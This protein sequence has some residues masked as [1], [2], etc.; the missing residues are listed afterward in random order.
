MPRTLLALGLLLTALGAAAGTPMVFQ[1]LGLEE[2]LS[3][4]TVNASLQDSRGF[5]WFATENGLNRFDGYTVTRFLRD[6][7]D[8]S[9]LESDFIWGQTHHLLQPFSQSRL[10]NDP[11]VG[12]AKS[13]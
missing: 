1:S 3:Q 13:G 9:A 7:D 10:R 2:G 4:S 5:M 12:T 11:F 6:A 8:P